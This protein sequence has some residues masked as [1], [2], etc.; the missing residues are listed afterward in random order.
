MGAIETFQEAAEKD[1]DCVEAI[2]N[3]GLAYRSAEQ[4]EEALR[5]FEKLQ[6]I[7]PMNAEVIYNIAHIHEILGNMRQ[8]TKWFNILATRV[9][10]DPGILSRLGSIYHREEDD[11]QAFHYHLESYRYYPVNM[12]VISWLGAYFVKNELYEKA[13]QFFERAAQIQPQETKWKLMVASCHRRIQ[14]FSRAL[15]IYQ[16]I[17]AEHP[18]NIECLRFL[19]HCCSEQQM[20]EQ[21]HEYV[22]KLRK[23]ER[24]EEI[25]KNREREEQEKQNSLGF[26]GG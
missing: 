18:D 3:L 13:M 6:T 19:V 7:M 21:A 24:A 25:E 17:H 9:P 10:T 15:Q 26:G 16:E 8:T 14:N 23:A 11:S 1:S 5:C 2:Y 12:E 22:L 4:H 20:K